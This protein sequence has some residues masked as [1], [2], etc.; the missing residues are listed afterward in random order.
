MCS[1]SSNKVCV[2]RLRN[3]LWR[4]GGTSGPDIGG[5]AKH[6]G[7]AKSGFKSFR[8]VPEKLIPASFR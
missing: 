4:S 1:P 7:A 2:W 5:H 6:L 8:D 3:P